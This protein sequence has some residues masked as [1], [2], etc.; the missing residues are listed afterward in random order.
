MREQLWI[1]T[2]FCLLIPRKRKSEEKNTAKVLISISLFVSTKTWT[3]N[4]TKLTKNWKKNK[5]LLFIFSKNSNRIDFIF[6]V[7]RRMESYC[8][9]SAVQQPRVVPYLIIYFIKYIF[10]LFF[11]FSENINFGQNLVLISCETKY[12]I[13]QRDMNICFYYILMRFNP[14]AFKHLKAHSLNSLLCAYHRNRFTKL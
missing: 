14:K 13:I 2:H 8:H 5:K 7:H 11:K 3:S 10:I 12:I 6:Y 1:N 9:L 4:C